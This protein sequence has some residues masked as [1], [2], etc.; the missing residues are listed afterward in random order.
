V[1]GKS[2][3]DGNGKGAGDQPGQN[4]YETEITIDELVNLAFQELGLPFLENKGKGQMTIKSIRCDTIRK[5]GAQ[6]NLDAKRTLIEAYK[7][8]AQEG[9]RSWEIDPIYDPRYKAF[10]EVVEPEHNA[11]VLAMRDISGSM[12]EQ[13]AYLCRTFFTWM[14]RFLRQCYSSVAIVFITCH[15][16]A[17]EVDEDGFFHAGSS[18]G[19]QMASALNLCLDIIGRRYDPS[20]WNIYPFLFSDGDDFTPKECIEPVKKLLAVSNLFGYGEI[21]DTSAWE[22]L[23]RA[24][25][26]NFKDDKRLVMVSLADASMVW[27][28]LKQFLYHRHRELAA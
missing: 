22:D 13:E 17:E 14:V 12:G 16:I 11:V 24:L 26:E 28:A 25:I 5:K 6:S 3:E 10:D 4:I 15:T 2:G 27:Q 8:N 19:T 18:G 20:T 7:R 1:I 21:N 23:G 9:K